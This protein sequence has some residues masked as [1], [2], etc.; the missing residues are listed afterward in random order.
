MKKTN[1]MA[2]S[3]SRLHKIITESVKKVLKE[4]NGC[5]SELWEKMLNKMLDS[6]EQFLKYDEQCLRQEGIDAKGEE[7]HNCIKNAIDEITSIA[8][9]ND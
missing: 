4:E 5:N 9:S 3:E 2:I 8:Y 1:K 7:L 6:M